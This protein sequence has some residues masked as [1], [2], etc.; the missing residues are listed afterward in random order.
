MGQFYCNTRE[1][2]L[3]FWLKKK[4][5]SLFFRVDTIG[6]DTETAEAVRGKR[7]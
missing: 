4:V 5:K 2:Q 7:L 6:I 1:N 3:F